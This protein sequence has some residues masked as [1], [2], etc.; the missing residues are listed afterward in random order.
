MLS[1]A[2]VFLLILKCFRPSNLQV[3][4]TKFEFWKML[5]GKNKPLLCGCVPSG[6]RTF[7]LICSGTSLEQYV[8]NRLKERG[9]PMLDCPLVFLWVQMLAL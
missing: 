7:F 3:I 9:Q 6:V 4:S 1:C 2:L 5:N 8:H